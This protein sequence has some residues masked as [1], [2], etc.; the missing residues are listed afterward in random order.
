MKPKYYGNEAGNLGLVKPFAP[1]TFDAF[2][3]EVL[4]NCATV[5]LSRKR[6]NAMPKP[7]R[8]RAKRVG[9]FCPCTFTSESRLMES[10]GPANLIV[11]DLDDESSAMAKVYL[12]TPGALRGALDPFPFAAYTSASHTADAPRLRVVVAAEGIPLDRYADAVQTIAQQLALTSVTR[13][14]MVPCQPMFLPTL[15]AGEDETVDHPLFDTRFDGRPFVVGDIDG[16]VQISPAKVIPGAVSED[17]EFL[18]A[19][20]LD[21]TLTEAASA[22]SAI[23]PDVG[24]SEWLEV[25]AALRHQFPK[26]PDEAYELFD[27]WS[28]KGKKYA[29]E[30]D[31]YAKWASLRVTPKGRRPIT[32]RTLLSRAAIAGWSQAR[33]VSV[34]QQEAVRLWIK[35]PD[36]QVGELMALGARRIASLPGL[37]EIERGALV[38]S[39]YHALRTRGCTARAADIRKEVDRFSKVAFAPH[40]EIKPTLGDDKLPAWLRG[41]TYVAQNDTF[42]YRSSERKYDVKS[43]NNFF[44]VH[45][46]PTQANPDEP[47]ID[48]SKPVMAAASYALNVAR[49]PRVDILE[50]D[51]SQESSPYLVRQDLR[52]LNTYLPT[53]PEA[54]EEGSDAAGALITEHV[55]KLFSAGYAEI[56]LDWLA[57]QVQNPGRKIRW[58]PL[59]QGVEGC[60]KTAL[61]IMMEKVLGPSNVRITDA[62]MLFTSFTN[63][64]EGRQ[65]VVFEEVRVVG[66]SRHEVMNKLKPAITNDTVTVHLKGV[67][68]F[69][70][71]NRSN[72]L[73]LTN[74]QDA[75]P[76]NDGNRR[77]F[78][79]FCRQQT[80]KELERSFPPGYFATLFDVINN[81]AGQVRHWLLK[82]EI[83][84]SFDPDGHAPRTAFTDKLSTE[85]STPALLL[86]QDCLALGNNPL[87]TNAIISARAALDHCL[88]QGIKESPQVVAAALRDLGYEQQERAAVNGVMHRFYVNRESPLYTSSSD[89]RLNAIGAMIRKSAAQAMGVE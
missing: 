5:N 15:F 25:A 16:T 86:I 55:H 89:S 87:I 65:L 52:M 10:A 85:A 68:A 40:D 29:G 9:Y 33:E 75:L 82:R 64:C 36:R 70:V 62:A 42:V 13:E 79:L 53:Y 71:A 32:I 8:D 1:E 44:N 81:Q 41:C 43:F 49:I 54:I 30:K 73:L 7:E 3:K 67:D 56:M 2:V 37:G 34:R 50:Y 69:Q 4:G 18:A 76:I 72:Y 14:S 19:P 6:F 47:D 88:E 61:A 74:H 39:L 11:L 84:S 48:A 21:I 20:L 59:I 26:Q 80:R 24:Y 58:A 38:M 77:Y 57:Y 51:P 83:A 12:Q 78:V 66:S 17:L 22:L 63:W 23:S 28:S 35:S 46:V 45:L 31:T 60:G 27:T